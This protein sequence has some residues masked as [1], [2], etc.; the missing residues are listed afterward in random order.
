MRII[1]RT[2]LV[3]CAVLLAAL[4]GLS[5]YSLGGPRGV[6]PRRMIP[7]GA[8]LCLAVSDLDGRWPAVASSDLWNKLVE[9]E[10]APERKSFFQRFF[11]R[12]A[13][14]FYSKR[15]GLC[16]ASRL[17]AWQRG[18]E[19]PW[20][21]WMLGTGG[22][23]TRERFRSIELIRV[24]QRD[25]SPA[26]M[27]FVYGDLG[28]LM[29]GAD[30]PRMKDMAE[31]LLGG[32]GRGVEA[33]E[34]CVLNHF[35]SLYLRP[36]KLMEF[37]LRGEYE[38]AMGRYTEEY[39]PPCWAAVEDINR[40]L[41]ESGMSSIFDVYS[42]VASSLDENEAIVASLD[43]G[44]GD[45]VLEWR[46]I[47][48]EESKTGGAGLMRYAAVLPDNVIAAAA[49]RFDTAGRSGG[50]PFPV[51]I[52]PV[53][54]AVGEAFDEKTEGILSSLEGSAVLAIGRPSLFSSLVPACAI[55]RLKSPA[56]ITSRVNSLLDTIAGREVEVSY[57]GFAEIFESKAGHRRKSHGGCEY[58][59]LEKSGPFVWSYAQ[60]GD[61]LIIA[62]HKNFL[63]S[64][65]D[66]EGRRLPVLSSSKSFTGVVETLTGS[67]QVEGFLD[68][69]TLSSY[70]GTALAACALREA[71]FSP[72]PSEEEDPF[73]PL[74][75]AIEV[76][77]CVGTVAWEADA[78]GGRIIIPISNTKYI[79]AE[80]Q[81]AQR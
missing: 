30:F 5:F 46:R 59:I 67:G 21:L 20:R 65:I 1:K 81:R 39:L 37:D 8:P 45:A 69:N 43:M 12:E 57:P 58:F 73:A 32:G 28:F 38:K 76:L 13:V 66:A 10:L 52:T 50:A 27:Y 7:P 34:G 41:T 77:G 79:T 25:D 16:V 40:A 33:F 15:S 18:V 62:T 80:T 6:S 2:L 61:L 36:G 70:A 53:E 51:D 35:I 11:G 60:L 22:D 24:E 4:I 14:A 68:I 48:A 55:F 75:T 56:D 44:V 47:G 9:L 42:E 64:V 54:K 17:S 3:F 19:L 29:I 74:R 26:F 31:L 72:G 23:W 71:L 63:K 49:F 78:G